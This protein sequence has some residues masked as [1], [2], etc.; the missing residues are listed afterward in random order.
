MTEPPSEEQP[1]SPELAEA[2]RQAVALYRDFDPALREQTSLVSLD[3]KPYSIC[4]VCR[5]VGGFS[6]PLPEG[7]LARLFSYMH[8]EHMELERDLAKNRSYATAARCLLK[9]IEDRR[10]THQRLEERRRYLGF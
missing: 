4:E 3:Q 9:L 6:D 7:L 8:A 5:L 2:F 10:V 1:I